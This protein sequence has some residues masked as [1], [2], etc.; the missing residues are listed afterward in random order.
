MG[1]S[2]EVVTFRELDEASNRIA[3]L[4][5]QAGLQ[6]GDH[7]ALFMENQQHFMEVVWAALRSGLY[8]TAINS[9]LTA[10]E[11]AYIAG[12]C[13]AKA[14]VTSRAQG[15]VAAAM[16][17][18][19]EELARVSLRLMTNGAMEGF[20]GYE[21]S[22]AAQPA[23][24][25]ADESSGTTML[26]SS[27]TTGRPKGVLRPL[28][29]NTPAEA[30]AR[31]AALGP[32]YGF[33]DGMVYLSPAPMYHA[34]PLAFSIS[35]QRWGGT[36]VIMEKFDPLRALELIERCGVTHSQWVPTM[37][38]RLLRLSDEERNRFDL[39]SHQVAIHAAAPCPVPVK[40]QMIDWWGPIIY[41]YYAGTEGNGSTMTDSHEWLQK[42]GTVGRAR[43]GVV[44]IV[45]P[46][47]E[48]L[49]PGE[50]GNVYFEGGATFEYHNDPAKTEEA[51]D[52]KGRGWSTL[53]DVGYLDEDGYLF[54]TDRKAHM[55]ISG[56]VNIY[57]REIEDVFIQHP[58]VGDVAVFGVPNAEFGEEVK[59]VVQPLDPDAAG[60]ELAAELLS[61]VRQHLAGFKCPRSIDFR[62]QLPRLPTGKL[63]KRILV[64]EYKKLAA[65]TSP[66]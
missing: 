18:N 24:P 51:H 33:H 11:V 40:H 45:G 63:Y 16:D 44:H 4:L 57:P 20:Q 42:P 25:I 48:E 1:G 58:A 50:E 22:V 61:F 30:D 17:W 43:A 27:G 6:R 13:G 65:G 53:G 49:G 37:F 39:S 64:D 31:A 66:D 52:P 15:E 19:G 5:R 28:P 60:D 29:E 14:F 23:V 21:D 10:E 32:T 56:G 38:V 55:I 2:G 46:D 41:E 12:D 26:Y 47:G 54:L 8:L 9:H 3:H 59:A 36:V 35:A 62:E 7:I 34:A